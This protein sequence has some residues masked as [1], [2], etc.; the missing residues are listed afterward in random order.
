MGQTCTISDSE[1]ARRWEGR[2]EHK[3]IIG[4]FER[5]FISFPFSKSNNNNE[6]SHN[7]ASPIRLFSS[8]ISTV[9]G[10][11]SHFRIDGRDVKILKPGYKF[12]TGFR[13]NTLPNLIGGNRLEPNSSALGSVV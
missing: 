5:I 11:A 3:V 4:S 8:E 6:Q 12:K 9:S 10:Q 7:L 1:S 13:K 2:G